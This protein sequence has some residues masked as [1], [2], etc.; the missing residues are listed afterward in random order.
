MDEN[1]QLSKEDGL[2]VQEFAAD[3]AKE[4]LKFNI[5]EHI[6]TLRSS[7][8]GWSRE[9]NIV[10]WNNGKA[11]FDV[12]DWSEDHNKMS[13]GLTFTDSEMK[14]I[15]DWLKVRGTA[16]KQNEEKA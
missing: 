3:F 9:L 5:C 1:Y 13:K 2:Q 11:K 16:I 10:S 15:F 14:R 8:S 12:R 6:G 7:A 4:A